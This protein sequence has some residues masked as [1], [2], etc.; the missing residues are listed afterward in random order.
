MYGT[1][2]GFLPSS[3]MCKGIQQVRHVKVR[4]AAKLWVGL[5]PLSSAERPPVP[6]FFSFFPSSFPFWQKLCFWFSQKEKVF[7]GT[8]SPRAYEVFSMS[9]SIPKARTFKIP[10]ALYVTVCG[11]V[12]VCVCPWVGEWVCM[13]RCHSYAN[14]FGIFP[15]LIA[16]IQL[17][18][19]L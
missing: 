11:W 19:L 8:L 18:F 13:Y 7:M 12:G 17:H 4:S 9:N 3:H 5:R 14:L 15:Q 6:S 1:N 10:S 16:L 2:D